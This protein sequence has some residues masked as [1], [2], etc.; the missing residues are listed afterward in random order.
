MEASNS[1]LCRGEIAA[2][3]Q[4]L[5]VVGFRGQMEGSKIA[6]AA[7]EVWKSHA[8]DASHHD[9]VHE[10]DEVRVY[11]EPDGYPAFIQKLEQ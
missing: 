4:I 8:D 10:N 5:L 7:N 11:I 6:K 9:R 3:S 2:L 1:Y